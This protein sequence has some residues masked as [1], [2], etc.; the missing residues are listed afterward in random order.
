MSVVLP[1]PK[2]PVMIVKGVLASSLDADCSAMAA[3]ALAS[4]LERRLNRAP[5]DH[6][7][8][9]QALS[10]R[11]AL[12]KQLLMRRLACDGAVN[13]LSEARSARLSM[14]AST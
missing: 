1:A 12:S 3:V 4:L 7:G 8:E 13:T 11:S 6:N 2:K 5:A 14:Q 10:L 9:A